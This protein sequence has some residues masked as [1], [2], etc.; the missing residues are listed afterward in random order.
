MKADMEGFESAW[1][2]HLY[3]N[4]HDL[5]ICM[6]TTLAKYMPFA[7]QVD[8][9]ML[10]S[11]NSHQH[12]SKYLNKKLMTSHA[13]EVKQM[14]IDPKDI[15]VHSIRKG[16]ATYC[17][18]GATGALRIASICNRAGWSMG[19]VKDTYIHYAESGDQRRKTCCR[20]R[21]TVATICMHYALFSDT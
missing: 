21:C 4:P 10:F 17:C 15:A 3:A 20:T 6:K 5:P 13:V 8:Y 18:S 9:N 14:G 1:K 16:A 19:K 11:K 12:F 2:R 7:P